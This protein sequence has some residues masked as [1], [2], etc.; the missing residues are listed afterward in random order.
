MDTYGDEDEDSPAPPPTP[1]PAKQ[2]H[3]QIRTPAPIAVQQERVRKLSRGVLPPPA[4]NPLQAAL[5]LSK[6]RCVC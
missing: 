5:A 3:Q 1:S 4:A 2:L 6:V